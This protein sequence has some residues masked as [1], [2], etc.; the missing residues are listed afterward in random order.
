MTQPLVVYISHHLGKDEA[1]RRMRRGLEQ[2]SSSLPFLQIEHEEWSGAHLTF[3]LRGFGQV[4]NG[5]ANVSDSDV[6]VEVALPWLLQRFAEL[7]GNTIK[8]RTRILIEKK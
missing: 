1:I 7:V 6:R 8:T 3:S 2:A 4:A 5:S